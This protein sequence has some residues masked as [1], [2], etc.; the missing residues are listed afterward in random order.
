M[1]SVLNVCLAVAAALM[2]SV[3]FAKGNDPVVSKGEGTFKSAGETSKITQVTFEL[4]SENRYRCKL[5]LEDLTEI[6]FTGRYTG[7][8]YHRD[9]NLRHGM[10]QDDIDG[11]GE[12]WIEDNTGK[13][14]KIKARGEVKG[15]NFKIEFESNKYMRQN[16]G[17]GSGGNR[18][19]GG[20]DSEADEFS[21]ADNLYGTGRLDLGTEKHQV[22]HLRIKMSRNG[23]L[24][25]R[26]EGP[27]TDDQEW[28]GRWS[29][30]GPEY[31]VELRD[32]GH[33]GTKAKGSV[34]LTNNRRN[35]KKIEMDGE[36]EGEYFRLYFEAR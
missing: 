36:T 27:D 26:V 3:A 1:K 31:K 10:G 23:D 24:T 28:E 29:G 15:V 35:F 4:R 16:D 17:G 34:L 30:D 14:Q 8:G 12:I 9:I 13:L 6:E 32:R 22:D 11:S 20:R 5:Q 7:G 19:G 2:V 33:F 18:G 25:I 21:F